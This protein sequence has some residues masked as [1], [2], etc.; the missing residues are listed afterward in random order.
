MR[1]DL[2]SSFH[3]CLLYAQLGSWVCDFD[4]QDFCSL[5]DVDSLFARDSMCNLC[6]VRLVVHEQQVELVDV[7]DE[8][9]AKTVGHHVSGLA[10]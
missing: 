5:K 3:L 7:V 8:E 6:C 9:F 2:I 1:I 4:A 10:V